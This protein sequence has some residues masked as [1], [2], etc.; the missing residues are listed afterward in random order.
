MPPVCDTY[1]GSGYTCP[2]GCIFDDK[3]SAN[4][5][6]A[7]YVESDDTCTPPDCLAGFDGSEASCQ[8]GCTYSP[9]VST[10]APVGCA[11]FVANETLG[12]A[13]CEASWAV[14]RNSNGKWVTAYQACELSCGK[15]GSYARTCDLA[16]NSPYSIPASART[17]IVLVICSVGIA[18]WK[19]RAKNDSAS[20]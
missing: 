18:W 20:G 15:D 8:P 3:G 6:P 12:V 19:W 13:N 7:G 16:D 4:E 1:L 10:A 14:G 5:V 2:E 9:A 17:F 11:A